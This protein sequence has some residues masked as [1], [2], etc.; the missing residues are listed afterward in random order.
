MLLVANDL[1]L[2]Q[3]TEGRTM[4]VTNSKR[5]EYIKRRLATEPKA[6]TRAL[7]IIY[8][9]QTSDEQKSHSVIMYNGVGFTSNDANI[10]TNLVK[11]W[12]KW[13]RWTKKQES[14]LLKIMPKYARQ[15]IATSC[16]I[17]KLDRMIMAEAIA[18]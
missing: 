9:H 7:F 18:N 3:T 8:G 12:Q 10:L 6:A 1:Q 15:I 4:K 2:P 13:G 14:A 11:S 17:E 16:N 5:I